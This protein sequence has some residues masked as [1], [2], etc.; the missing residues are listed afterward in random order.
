M[1][2]SDGVALDGMYHEEHALPRLRPRPGPRPAPA[3]VGRPQ[4]RDAG[5]LLLHGEPQKVRVEVQFP[6]GIWTQW[7]PQA[8]GRRPA[9]SRAPPPADPA[10]RPDRLVRRRSSRPATA[11]PGAAGDL[12]R[13]PL[14][15][16]P[17]GRRGV[18]PDPDRDEGA[19]IRDETERFLFYRG[20]G[21]APLPVRFTADAGGHAGRRRDERHGVRPRLRAPGRGGPGRLRLPARR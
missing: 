4:G 3:A 12:G 19:D 14:E 10:G 20:L 16:R 9:V 18:R 1:S 15:L 2:G 7:Y 17:R 5:H 8:A 21:R 11:G 6:R 13:R